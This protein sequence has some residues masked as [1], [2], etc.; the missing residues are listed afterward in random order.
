MTTENDRSIQEASSLHSLVRPLTVFIEFDLADH[1]SG[2]IAW[3]WGWHKAQFKDGYFCRFWWLFFAVAWVR[4]DLH[5]Y[6][7]HIASGKTEWRG[8]GGK[9]PNTE[10]RHGGPDTK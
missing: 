1:G 6:N 4:M 10:V 3:R 7:R 8:A 5:D 9:G 2:R